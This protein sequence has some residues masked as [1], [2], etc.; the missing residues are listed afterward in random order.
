MDIEVL[1]SNDWKLYRPG[2]ILSEDKTFD[3]KTPDKS[4]VYDFLLQLDY[5]LIA[6]TLNT[7][8][9]QIK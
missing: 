7:L 8:F 1:K 2:F 5:R 6:K 4:E 9:F 3:I